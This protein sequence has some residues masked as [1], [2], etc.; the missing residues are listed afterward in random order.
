MQGLVARSRRRPPWAAR[1]VDLNQ[2]RRLVSG[3]SPEEA[4]RAV[5]ERECDP[6]RMEIDGDRQEVIRVAAVVDAPDPERIGENRAR[7]GQDDSQGD[8]ADKD[9]EQMLGIAR[10]LTRL[11]AWSQSGT[12]LHR[13]GPNRQDEGARADKPCCERKSGHEHRGCRGK[14]SKPGRVAVGERP[15]RRA[16]QQRDRRR[17]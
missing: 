3:M 17:D 12:T 7:H 9:R 15:Q 1:S 8:H 2:E 11:P 5:K 10:P 4:S 13:A 16:H 14:P 6:R